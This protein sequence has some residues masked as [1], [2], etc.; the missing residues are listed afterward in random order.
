[1]HRNSIVPPRV[2]LDNAATSWPKPP[3][4]YEAIDRYMRDCGAPA[5][6]SGYAEAV[7]VA[8]QVRQARVA[9]AR[10]VGLADPTHVIFTLNGTDALNLALHGLL[11]SGDHVV[12]TV[13]EHNS[14]LRPLGHLAAAGTIELTHVACDGTGL[15]DPDEVRRALRPNTRLV[16]MIHASNVTG[17]LQPLARVTQIA[18]EAGALMLCDAAQSL[19]HVPVDMASLGVDLLAAPGHKGLLAPLGTGILAI[20]SGL[21]AQL[22][23]VRQGGTGSRS[24]QTRQPDELPDK[25]EAG[26]LNVPGIVGL[27]AGVEYLESASVAGLEARGRALTARLLEG[28]SAIEGLRVLGPSTADERVPLVSVVLSGYD[29]QELA[30]GLDAAYRVQTRAG[31]H[32]AP[33]VHQALGPAQAGGTLRFSLGAFT[34]E[35][36]VDLAIHA[37]AEMA[38]G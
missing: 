32:C 19:G 31:L 4:V 35:E 8:A 14:V 6:R 30:L 16:A 18:H 9:V 23:S 12:T 26:N 21:E 20:R 22:D 10:L 25:Y 36:D 29:P 5:G 33:L 27:K 17:T 1:M 2:Y 15:I 37:L 7:E 13:V 24:Q 28:L 34:T 3:Q 38:Q 11:R